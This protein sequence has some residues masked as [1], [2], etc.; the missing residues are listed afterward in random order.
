MN[1]PTSVNQLTLNQ[2]VKLKQIEDT[3]LTSFEKGEQILSLVSG[4]TIEQINDL[5]LWKLDYY[6]KR[7]ALLRASQPNTK[8]NKWLFIKG[9]LYRLVKSE[10]HLNTNQFTAADTFA[11]DAVANFNKLAAIIYTHKGKFTDE[12]FEELSNY[13]ANCKVG[14]IYGAVFFYSNRFKHSKVIS[15]FYFQQSMKVIKERLMEIK[16]KNMDGIELSMALQAETLL[17]RMN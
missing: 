9:K 5:K 10:K 17:E 1:I 8:V 6:F 13:F 15:D 7:I 4:L 2:F 11:I 12:S 3:E 16:N 14:K